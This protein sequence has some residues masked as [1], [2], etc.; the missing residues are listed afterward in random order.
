MRVR[1]DERGHDDTALGVDDLGVGVL[2][3]KGGFLADFDDLRALVG[4]RAALK[5]ALR[6]C[7]A[8]DEPT[9][10]DKFHK[11]LLL[12]LPAAFPAA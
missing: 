11:M 3:A 2:G 6:A 7:V 5:V 12:F 10:G 9:V 8:G 1:V 4:D